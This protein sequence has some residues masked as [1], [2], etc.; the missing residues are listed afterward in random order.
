MRGK[1]LKWLGL[2]RP[3]PPR[4][5]T[6]ALGPIF[7]ASARSGRGAS[8][9]LREA[10]VGVLERG[11]VHGIVEIK[12]RGGELDEPATR[13]SAARP[14]EQVRAAWFRSPSPT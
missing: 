13:G 8:T 11:E 14:D 1:P 4:E 9:D 10:F 3:D 12:E 6:I 2:F 5:L 7:R